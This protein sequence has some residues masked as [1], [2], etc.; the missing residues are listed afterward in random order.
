[1]TLVAF[2]GALR[3]NTNPINPNLGVIRTLNL[4]IDDPDNFVAEQR[5]NRIQ[6]RHFQVPSYMVTE[7]A[8]AGT[9]RVRRLKGIGI[10]MQWILEGDFY[11]VNANGNP[12]IGEIDIQNLINDI[13]VGMT[14]LNDGVSRYLWF[15]PNL[16][17]NEPAEQ[18]FLV[19]PAPG[20]RLDPKERGTS[21][22]KLDL[23]TSKNYQSI[24]WA[25]YHRGGRFVGPATI[26]SSTISAVVTGAGLTRFKRDFIKGDEIY[27]AA[28]VFLGTV[29][30]VQSDT[31]LTLTGNA[32]A[33]YSGA[34][35][36]SQRSTNSFNIPI[37]SMTEF[38]ATSG[39]GLSPWGDNWG[40]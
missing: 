5:W 34:Y 31:S 28:G 1:M 27:S 25:Y 10:Q 39:W 18:W 32:A 4:A 3:V 23:T 33:T 16:N 11:T 30:S 2:H 13:S 21:G 12:S 29:L 37:Y 22:I 38:V 40:Q 35:I 6:W 24:T 20:C 17:W 7:A 14:G 8:A 9:T 26:S 19:T 36:V 15:C